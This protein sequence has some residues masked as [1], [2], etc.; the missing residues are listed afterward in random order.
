MLSSYCGLISAIG[1][2]KLPKIHLNSLE[3]DLFSWSK[4]PLSNN[5]GLSVDYINSLVLKTR[6]NA[7][8]TPRNQLISGLFASGLRKEVASKEYF[9]VDFLHF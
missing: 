4:V 2:G 1:A 7:G 5:L 8:L 3:V 9:P 6:S